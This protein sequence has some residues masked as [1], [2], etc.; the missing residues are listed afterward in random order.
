MRSSKASLSAPILPRP[1]GGGG[2]TAPNP[3][4]SARLKRPIPCGKIDLDALRIV[5]QGK[6][7]DGETSGRGRP[8][9]PRAVHPAR[10]PRIVR[11]QRPRGPPKALLPQG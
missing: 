8:A 5:R 7:D 9:G 10:S 1:G 2:P 4:P 11:P 6:K 3:P